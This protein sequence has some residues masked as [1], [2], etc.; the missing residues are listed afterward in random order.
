[1][2]SLYK[3]DP[4]QK[5]HNLEP[6]LGHI[7]YNF[8]KS[9]FCVTEEPKQ[10][11]EEDFSESY[12]HLYRVPK[13]WLFNTFFTPLDNRF[14][15]KEV[16]KKLLKADD[17]CA[18][19]LLEASCLVSRSDPFGPRVRAEWRKVF[20]ERARKTNILWNFKWDDKG[21][22][23]WEQSGIYSLFPAVPD[24]CDEDGRANHKY[25][26]LCV[27][28]AFKTALGDFAAVVNGEW[29]I[30]LNWKV[31][32]AEL[33]N[34]AGR[35]PLNCY[36]FLAPVEG[37]DEFAAPLYKFEEKQK[38]RGKDDAGAAGPGLKKQRS[39]RSFV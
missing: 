5:K 32:E 25:T 7:P 17:D 13:M 21:K 28:N 11:G 23:Q 36:D 8:P 24:D 9:N 1:M 10:E 20:G 14:D 2:P 38:K 31:R 6:I 33:I 29:T 3:S 34:V 26:H 15:G 4:P 30:R 18:M 22:M 12:D 37:W 39:A 16:V 27:G 19:K 35:N